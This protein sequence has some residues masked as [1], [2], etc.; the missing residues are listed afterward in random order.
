MGLLIT[1]GPSSSVSRGQGFGSDDADGGV[2]SSVGCWEREGAHASLRGGG[3][4]PA[5]MWDAVPC[6]HPSAVSIRVRLRVLIFSPRRALAKVSTLMLA[7]WATSRYSSPLA[8]MWLSMSVP[9]RSRWSVM[10]VTLQSSPIGASV[11]RAHSGTDGAAF[12]YPH[13]HRLL[14]GFHCSRG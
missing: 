4:P 6:S 5:R 13:G 10:G 9:R 3:L 8:I 11:C 2:S 12:L 1:C 14:P 7:R